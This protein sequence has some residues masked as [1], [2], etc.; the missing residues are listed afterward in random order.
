MSDRRYSAEEVDAAVE[1]VSDPERLQHAQ[2]IVVHA[3]P[4]L[5]PVLL[6]ALHEGGWFGQGHERQVAAALVEPDEGQRE[7]LVHALLMEETRLSLLVGAVVGFELARELARN[8][9][10]LGVSTGQ[11]GTGGPAGPSADRGEDRPTDSLL[12][13]DRWEPEP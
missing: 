9:D 8:D 13:T 3:A 4:T 7:K 5:Q 6:Q 10:P 1:A 2:E 11:R 12:H